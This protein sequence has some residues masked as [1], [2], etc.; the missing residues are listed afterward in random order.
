MAAKGD[1]GN[2]S[3]H[4]IPG[5]LTTLEVTI[6]KSLQDGIRCVDNY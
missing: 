3:D 1:P 2:I 5:T 4:R 6:A